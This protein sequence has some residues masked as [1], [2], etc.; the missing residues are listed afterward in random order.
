MAEITKESIMQQLHITHRDLHTTDQLPWILE[1][2]FSAA[3]LTQGTE[4][5]AK[6]LTR[7]NRLKEVLFYVGKKKNEG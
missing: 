5:S 3:V 6:I 1:K 7:Y 2:L 4:M